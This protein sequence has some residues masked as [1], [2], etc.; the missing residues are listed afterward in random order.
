LAKEKIAV[1]AGVGQGLGASLCRE[2]CS[3]GYH[4]AAVARK[5][6]ILDRLRDEADA[7]NHRLTP[8]ICDLLD[9]RSIEQAHASIKA[10]SGDISVY[11]H[12]ASLFCM[13]EYLKTSADIYE[14]V[15]RTT[16]L[17]AVH[18]TQLILPDMMS[19]KQGSL[20][21]TGATAAVRGGAEFAAFASAK[22]ALRGLS[23]SLARELGPQGIHVAHIVLDG[24][25]DCDWTRER[26]GVKKEK[27]L[28]PEEIAKIYR[29]LI[30]Q[31]PSA[32]TQEIDLRPSIEKF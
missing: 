23:Q 20:L 25:I 6:A 7:E 1:V 13:D 10:L 9:Q 8:V 5:P 16:C 32:W 26:F 29:F 11:I 24:I 14:N 30:E 3:C 19:H 15:W 27:A 12:N 21:F 18:F 28:Y 4:V 22:F 31:H 2:L 17:S